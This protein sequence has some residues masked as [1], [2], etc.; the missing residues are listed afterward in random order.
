M[1]RGIFCHR[2]NQERT[3]CNAA[4]TAVVAVAVSGSDSGKQKVAKGDLFEHGY[5]LNNN[6]SSS[7]VKAS[8]KKKQTE[9]GNK[10]IRA[11]TNY[12]NNAQ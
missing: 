8:E 6:R 7:Q 1:Q 4:A 9:N 3:C 12:Y 2:S 11:A 10:H 5:Q